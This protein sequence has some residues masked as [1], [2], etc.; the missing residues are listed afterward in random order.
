MSLKSRE[1]QQLTKGTVTDESPALDSEGDLYFIRHASDGSTNILKR[2]TKDVL[3]TMR[4]PE[5][6][7]GIRDLEINP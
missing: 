4:L 2:S 7:E 3:T 6:F 5:E 1:Y